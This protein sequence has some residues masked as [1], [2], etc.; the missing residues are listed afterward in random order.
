MEAEFMSFTGTA[1]LDTNVD[2]GDRTSPDREGGIC[3][4]GTAVLDTNVD[5]G[6]RRSSVHGSGIHVIY[7]DGRTRYQR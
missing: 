1:V 6:N 7:G 3:V 4:K 5:G 2:R